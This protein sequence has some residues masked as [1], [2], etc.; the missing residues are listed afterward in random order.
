MSTGTEDVISAYNIADSRSRTV[1][2]G[3]ALASWVCDRVSGDHI[4][5]SGVSTI[6]DHDT[7]AVA[8]EVVSGYG[9]S[10]STNEID[11]IVCAGEYHIAGEYFSPSAVH[12]KAVAIIADHIAG[13]GVVVAT[14]VVDSIRV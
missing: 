2:Q 7:P 1:I 14:V 5:F 9:Y 4:V 3:D 11:S 13:D 6:A 12:I 8:I 10:L